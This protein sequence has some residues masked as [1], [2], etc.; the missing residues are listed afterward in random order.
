MCLLSNMENWVKLDSEIELFVY[1][2]ACHGDY[3][4]DI[5]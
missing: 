1:D 3:Q 2:M 5:S 4:S